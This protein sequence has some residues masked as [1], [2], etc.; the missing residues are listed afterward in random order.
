VEGIKE[1][2]QRIISITS[3]KKRPAGANDIASSG[4]RPD[5]RHRSFNPFECRGNN[6]ATSNNMK[7]VHWP[8]MGRL[9]HLLQ[10]GGDRAGP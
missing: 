5:H 6:S 3:R 7:L 9:L 1:Y 4:C 8:L 2:Y 10:W